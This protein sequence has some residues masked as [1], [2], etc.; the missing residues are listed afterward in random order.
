MRHTF[1]TILSNLALLNIAACSQDPHDKSSTKEFTSQAVATKDSGKYSEMD[2]SNASQAELQQLWMAAAIE[3]ANSEITKEKA[4][5]ILMGMIARQSPIAF[6]DFVSALGNLSA[7][8]EH[9]GAGST[10]LHL[11]QDD[12]HCGVHER[13]IWCEGGKPGPSENEEPD[14]TGEQTQIQP[15]GKVLLT[16]D[17][18]EAAKERKLR[19]GAL[20]K[21]GQ[22][23]KQSSSTLNSPTAFAL[24]IDNCYEIYGT[25][26]YRMMFGTANG[27][28]AG[29][30]ADA[31]AGEGKTIPSADQ[32][33]KPAADLEP[34]VTVS[35]DPIIDLTPAPT[36]PTT[37]G[38][39]SNGS[40]S[41]AI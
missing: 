34:S 5:E 17:E 27:G 6:S 20:A 18:A 36:E 31:D 40:N 24:W 21:Q 16:S 7:N 25:L 10:A 9:H 22:L 15:T 30:D 12:R 37:D 28:G 23:E 29:A 39:G 11:L 8:Q 2:L 13:L 3:G 35:P 32:C 1:A 33:A 38:S 41:V 4:D 14:C 19:A 26:C